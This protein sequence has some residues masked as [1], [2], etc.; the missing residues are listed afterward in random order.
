MAATTSSHPAT[1][2]R[3]AD[4]SCSFIDDVLEAINP[5][6]TSRYSGKQIYELIDMWSA[7]NDNEKTDLLS[8][9]VLKCI[10]TE[11]NLHRNWQKHFKDADQRI[12]KEY[13]I[14][15]GLSACQV[16]ERF[17][18]ALTD[19]APH[20]KQVLDDA[21]QGSIAPVFVMDAKNWRSLPGP[22]AGMYSEYVSV[23]GSAAISVM[24]LDTYFKQNL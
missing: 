13:G 20:L 4:T 23:A 18:R 22:S 15:Q 14:K 10:H 8:S 11:M 16:S 6:H 5:E 24:T 19:A 1:I 17:Q 7:S 9:I 3:S 21:C 2:V 12:Q